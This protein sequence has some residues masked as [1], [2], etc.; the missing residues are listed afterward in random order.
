MMLQKLEARGV[1]FEDEARREDNMVGQCR[2]SHD[3]PV[4]IDKSC[5]VDSGDQRDE[6]PCF[7]GD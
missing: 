3:V 2:T 5:V 4:R 7:M 6:S 1:A